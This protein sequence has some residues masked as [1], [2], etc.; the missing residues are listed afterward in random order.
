MST[1]A[2]KDLLMGGRDA[3]DF[4]AMETPRCIVTEVPG[5]AGSG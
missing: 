4:T 5:W 2:L 3:L 1:S